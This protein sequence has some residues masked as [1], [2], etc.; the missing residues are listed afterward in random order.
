MWTWRLI[1]GMAC[2]ISHCCG[3]RRERF[4]SAA[5]KS[6]ACGL[7]SPSVPRCM[8]LASRCARV[9]GGIAKRRKRPI[10]P[11]RDNVVVSDATGRVAESIHTPR[12]TR[13]SLFQCL[14][15]LSFRSPLRD[16]ILS[17]DALTPD[18]CF[19]AFG[20]LRVGAPSDYQKQRA[21]LGAPFAPRDDGFHRFRLS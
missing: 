2:A 15:K 17:L 14:P 21:R 10:V 1:I 9:R 18:V 16:D 13:Q 19:P 4:L 20:T 11:L 6:K 3:D 8:P 12:R 5:G 7:S